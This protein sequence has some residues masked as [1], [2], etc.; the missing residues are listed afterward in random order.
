M[1]PV[2]LIVALVYTLQWRRYSVQSFGW[3]QKICD[4]TRVVRCGWLMASIVILLGGRAS[5]WMPREKVARWSFQNVSN[6]YIF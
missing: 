5:R 2:P 1:L 4:V 3:R 6:I